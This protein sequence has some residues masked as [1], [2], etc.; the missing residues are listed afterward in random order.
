VRHSLPSA[1][2]SKQAARSDTGSLKSFRLPVFI[3]AAAL[4]RLPEKQAVRYNRGLVLPAFFPA[5][6]PP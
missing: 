2:P 5:K 3:A 6:S 4:F 1:V